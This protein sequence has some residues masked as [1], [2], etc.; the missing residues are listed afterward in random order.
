VIVTALY[1]FGVILL[2]CGLLALF[3]IFAFGSASAVG[4]LVVGFVLI[5]VAFILSRR[6]IP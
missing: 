3:G 5:I 2:I 6:A 4:L 1:V